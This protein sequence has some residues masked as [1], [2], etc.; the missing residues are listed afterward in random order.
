MMT[1]SKIK[2]RSEI[3]SEIQHVNTTREPRVLVMTATYNERE[4]LPGLSAEVFETLPDVHFLVVDDNSPDGTGKW[5]AEQV[6][7]DDRF[8]AIHRI[9]K[10]GLGTAIMAGMKWAIEHD[11]DYVVNIDADYSHHPRYLP[12]IVAGMDP[13]DAPPIDVMIG[14]RYIPGGGVDGWPWHRRMMSKMVN[15]YARWF[16]WLG[17]QDI[18]G[19]Y[20]CYRTSTLKKID[21]AT[22]R[23]RG[24]SFQ[25]EI[26]WR[27]KKVGA[28]FAESPIVFTD[29]RWGE[30]KI[31]KS[32]AWAALRIIARLGFLG[33]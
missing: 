24:Y 26:L 30:S 18:S 1:G 2:S 5:A 4:N 22:I 17:P 29:R 23:S 14:S 12:A 13:A 3:E 7:R 28:R 11:F 33:G 8:H 20:R 10:Q 27:L 16:L 9:G 6:A 19:G 31:N 21:F 32:E 15:I 25:E